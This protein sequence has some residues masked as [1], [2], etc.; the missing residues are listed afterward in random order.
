M[1]T[2]RSDGHFQLCGEGEHLTLY[3]VL[4]DSEVLMLSAEGGYH[5]TVLCELHDSAL[6]A[7]LG[8]EKTL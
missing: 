3:R 2:Q 6:G 5:K 7:H 8:A 4:N 1:H